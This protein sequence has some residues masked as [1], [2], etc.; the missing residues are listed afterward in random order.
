MFPIDLKGIFEEK[1]AVSGGLKF[2]RLRSRI[3]ASLNSTKFF[4]FVIRKG[5]LGKVIPMTAS[6]KEV[7]EHYKDKD[8]YLRIYVQEEACF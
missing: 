3:Q 5:L 7:Y 2:E 1:L 8:G 6:V 4:Y